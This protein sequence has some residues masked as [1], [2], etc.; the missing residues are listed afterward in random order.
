MVAHAQERNGNALRNAGIANGHCGQNL[1]EVDLNNL[2]K[3]QM[4]RTDST[5]VTTFLLMDRTLC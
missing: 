3:R 5:R 1:I 2:T 4:K